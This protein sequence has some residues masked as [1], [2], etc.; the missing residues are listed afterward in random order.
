[1]VQVEWQVEVEP[2][3][4]VGQVEWQVEVE[5]RRTAVAVAEELHR[6]QVEL[7]GMHQQQVKLKALC[8]QEVEPPHELQ[9]GLRQVEVGL[10]QQE[11]LEPLPFPLPLPCK[12]EWQWYAQRKPQETLK[13]LRGLDWGRVWRKVMQLAHC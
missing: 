5:G 13:K 3:E 7:E 6:D 8:C 11:A 2:Q 1:M 9:L 12:W 10:Q 4:G